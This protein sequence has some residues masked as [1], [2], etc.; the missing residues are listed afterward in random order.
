MF[1]SAQKKTVLA[2]WFTWNA[3]ALAPKPVATRTK[4][5]FV[6]LSAW[7]DVFAHQELCWTT[8]FVCQNH[9]VRALTRESNTLPGIVEVLS[10][11]NG[12]LAA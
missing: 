9:N 6:F 1:F 7:T 8:T 10:A 11:K 12:K 5:W 3:E 4:Q 2:T